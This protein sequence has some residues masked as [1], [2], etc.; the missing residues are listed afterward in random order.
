MPDS[1]NPPLGCV[2]NTPACVDVLDMMMDEELRF[3]LD[4]LRSDHEELTGKL[5]RHFFCPILFRDEDVPLCKGH[6]INRVFP[7]SSRYWTVQ[8]KD[9]DNFYGSAFESDFVDIQYR[10]R[11][12]PEEVIGKR[13]LSRKFHPT[14][15]RDGVSVEHY[16]PIGP[17]PQHFT[18][19]QFGDPRYDVRLGLKM[20]PDDA[21]SATTS[22]WEIDIQKD[23]RLAA[24]VSLIKSAHLTLFEMLGYRYALSAGGHFLGWSIL[25]EF[26]LKNNGLTKREITDNAL[27]YF[28]EFQHMVRPLLT[29]QVRGTVADRLVLICKADSGLHWAIVVFIR[30]SESLHAVLIP[31]FEQAEAAAHFLAFLQNQNEEVE[32]V[33]ALYQDGEWRV[34]TNSRTIKWPKSGILYPEEQDI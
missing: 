23:V 21:L 34:E 1:I 25:G 27:E 26:F 20:N 11:W 9:V 2:L 4:N 3:K 24:L 30:T 13:N 33:F 5:F 17:V 12:A 15:L 18:E 32:V 19:V 28:R 10:K 14:L 29:V 7:G 16:I 8:R 6:I 31:V 22:N